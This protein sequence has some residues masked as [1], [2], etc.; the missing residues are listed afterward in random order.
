MWYS[1]C[2]QK[3]RRI[4]KEVNNILVYVKI[5][6]KYVDRDFQEYLQYIIDV[7]WIIWHQF[8]S[9]H[10]RGHIDL[11]RVQHRAT[12]NIPEIEKLIYREMSSV[13]DFPALDERTNCKLLSGFDC[14]HVMVGWDREELIG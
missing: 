9:P 1:A 7:N 5:A 11:I 4:I 6:F 14:Q 8:S 2:H 10:F 3:A 12:K 13:I